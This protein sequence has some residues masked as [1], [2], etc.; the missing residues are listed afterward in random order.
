MRPELLASVIAGAVIFGLMFAVGFGYMLYRAFQQAHN[1]DDVTGVG[2]RHNN[3][4]LTSFELA[5]LGRAQAAARSV[6]SQAS[7]NSLRAA[8]G[9]RSVR[10]NSLTSMQPSN[11]SRVNLHR[12]GSADSV[13]VLNGRL[14][15]FMDPKAAKK[16]KKR[17]KSAESRPPLRW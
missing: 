3:N 2:R 5:E 17:S 1:L 14:P 10:S 9:R 8:G 13:G 15:D 6:R 11:N 12:Q 16:N 4:S 7:T